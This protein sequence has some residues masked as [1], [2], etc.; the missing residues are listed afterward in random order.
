MKGI[1]KAGVQK[2]E[3]AVAAYFTAH[4]IPVEPEAAEI[5]RQAAEVAGVMGEAVEAE[6]AP[7]KKKRAKKKLPTEGV[8]APTCDS[9]DDALLLRSAIRLQRAF[10]LRR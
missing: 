8:V 9:A 4:P 10:R 1:A 3:D 5:E 6:A 2:I 7:E